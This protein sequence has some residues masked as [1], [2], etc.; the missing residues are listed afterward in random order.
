MNM[1]EIDEKYL[2][3]MQNIEAV[4]T[5]AYRDDES[6]TDYSVMTV[7]EALINKYTAEETDRQP[8]PVRLSPE[9]QLL[10]QSILEVC[11]WRLGRGKFTEALDQSLPD[12][13][14]KT[15]AEIILVL[16]RLLKSVKHWNREGGSQGYL[17]YIS[18]FL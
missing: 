2:D 7:L 5:S 17:N 8:R 12:A 11:E 14:R 9:E 1:K 13:G 4:I 10:A 6:M 15:V 3:V 16:K 18:R